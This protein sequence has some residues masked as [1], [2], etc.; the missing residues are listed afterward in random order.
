MISLHIRR[1]DYVTNP[2]HPLQNLNYYSSA[3]NNFDSNLNVII[4]S[5]D[6]QWVKNQDFF[7]SDRFLVSDGGDTYIDLCLMTLCKYHIIANSSYSWWGAWLSKSEKVISPKNW[8]SGI[9][10]HYNTKDIYCNDWIIL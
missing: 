2:H 5:D 4:F 1:G 10:S 7:E 6:S 3:L 8:F 9:N